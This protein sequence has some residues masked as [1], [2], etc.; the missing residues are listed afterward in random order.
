MNLSSKNFTKPEY[1]ILGYNLNFIPTP[2][3]IDK[4]ELNQDLK[5]FGRR[6]KLRDHFGE[7]LTEKPMF[8]TNSSWEPGNNHHTVKT[9]LED[10]SRKVQC[11]L[12]NPSPTSNQ[13][14]RKNLNQQELAALENLKSMDDII[15]TKADKGGAVVVQ[16]VQ[17]Y[18]KEAER[19]LQ[20]QSFYKKLSHNPTGEHAALVSNAIDGL[21]QRELLD[22][23]MAKRLKPMNPKTP[24]LY[25]LPK[26]HKD[27]NPGRPVVSSV[28]CHTERISAFVD[29]HLQPMNRQLPSFVQDTTDFVKKI[30]AVPDDPSG[31]TILVSMDVRSL[32]TNIPNAEG[33]EAIKGFFRERAR[34]GD[35]ALSKVIHTFLTLIL[36]LNN[37]IFNDENYIQINGCSMGTKCAPPYASLFMGWFEKAYIY[38]RIQQHISM[39]VRYIDDI[40][41]VWKGTEAQLK[42]FLEVINTVH[43]TIKFDAKHSRKKIEFLDTTVI[44]QN[45]IL[46]TTLFTKPTDRR[47]YLHA[48]SYHPNSTKKSIAFSQACRLRRICS[49]LDE[50]WIHAE[51]L[52]KDLLNRGYK[53]EELS[54]EIAR[55]AAQDRPSLLTYKEKPTSSKIP[56][57][58][59]YNRTL[60]N[61]KGILDA[62]W[63]HLKIN[64][65][66]HKKFTEKPIL[67][68]KRNKNLRDEIGQTRLSRNRVVR[69]GAINNKGRCSPCLGRSDCLCCRHIIN[70]SYFTDREGKRKYDIRHR[71]S[72]KSKNAVYLGFCLKCN[73]RQYVGKVESQGANR[74]VN[75]HRNDAKREDSIAI[76]RHFQ[77]PGHDFNRDFRLIIIEEITKRNLTTEQNRELL[78]RR[79]DFWIMKLGTL[80]PRGFNDRLNYPAESHN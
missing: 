15:I 59:T 14:V 79:E 12:D 80:E 37:F 67:C 32:Y 51:Q 24:K 71:T 52:K 11:E 29:H 33:I 78:Q 64:P 7:S 10:F 73:D 27:G 28:E 76:D 21:R 60:P 20:D 18:I 35:A 57:I 43:P 77:E 45:G 39:Y 34:P 5:K 70:T 46:T 23:K 44:H 61:M 40:F 54:R 25:L 56:M 68:Y 22:E 30:E 26:I 19:Q 50:F 31:E 36:T 75:K 72:C 9:F 63:D 53:L 3:K 16:D 65:E 66:T 1:K 13:R 69:K 6:I 42:E 74:R 47:A 8:K 4:K 62:T 38:P 2:E 48:K 41:F 49:S 17:K 58:V 55:A